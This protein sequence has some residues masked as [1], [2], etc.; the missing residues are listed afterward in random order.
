MSALPSARARALAFAAILLAGVCGA[1]IGSS[2]VNIQCEGD[3]VTPSGL[4]AIVGAV[5]SAGGVALVAVL[6][7][8]A[9]GEW[10]SIG[11][12]ATRGTGSGT[13]S[14]TGPGAEAGDGRSAGPPLKRRGEGT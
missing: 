12:Q 11:S 10:R 1:L 13:G 2:L 7:L 5:L 4:A 8:R 9:M 6:V 3:C 14:G